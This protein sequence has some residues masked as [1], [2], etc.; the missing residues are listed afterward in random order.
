MSTSSALVVSLS[1]NRLLRRFIHSYF[2]LLHVSILHILFRLCV[3]HLELFGIQA[4]NEFQI[5]RTFSVLSITRRSSHLYDISLLTSDN[6]QLSWYFCL[7]SL[8]SWQSI[9]AH[10]P[11]RSARG[12][13]DYPH[14]ILYDST[15]ASSQKA[16]F[17]WLMLSASLIGTSENQCE[18]TG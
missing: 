11:S 4:S 10:P 2:F 7:P 17:S 13:S 5:Q 16:S 12:D 18:V 8:S 1:Q 14:R 6:A 9:V 15:S 3:V